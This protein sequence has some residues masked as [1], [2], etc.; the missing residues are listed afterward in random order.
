[1]TTVTKRHETLIVPEPGFASPTVALKLAEIADVHAKLERGI[2]E[3][4]P[5]ALAWQP[6]PGANTIGMLV[7]HIAINE[8]HLGQVGLRGERD[9]HV[10]DVLGVGPDED[11]LPIE[12]FGGRPP[13]ALEGKPAAFFLD[14]LARALVHSRDAARTLRDGVLGEE[15]VRP[16]RPDG[17]VRVF[18]QRWILHHMVEHAA[19]HLGQV[20][21]LRRQWKAAQPGA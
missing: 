21:T 4:P 17:S 11:G 19:Q 14:L 5:E 2:R 12:Q 9:G 10:A 15:I 3:L 8:V 7:A 20:N 1:M 16:P 6:A 13:R 18:D